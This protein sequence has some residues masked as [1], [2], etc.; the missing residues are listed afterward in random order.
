MGLIEV[1][2]E[3]GLESGIGISHV[4]IQGKS[5]PGR[6]NSQCKGHRQSSQ[7]DWSRVS[8]EPYSR[9]WQVRAL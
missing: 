1:I 7:C 9:R 5:V 4:T 8:K 3:Q 2:F 6:K